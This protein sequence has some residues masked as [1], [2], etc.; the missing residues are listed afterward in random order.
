MN[1]IIQQNNFNKNPLPNE[2]IHKEYTL[3][4]SLSLIHKKSQFLLILLQKLVLVMIIIS[5]SRIILQIQV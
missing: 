3:N 4:E 5:Y 2:I 1:N